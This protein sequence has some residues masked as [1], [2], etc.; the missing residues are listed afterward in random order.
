MPGGG[1]GGMLDLFEVPRGLL[2]TGVNINFYDYILLRVTVSDPDEDD[3]ELSYYDA[4][5]NSL[6]STF[7]NVPS[8]GNPGIGFSILGLSEGGLF[9]W[10]V[11]VS[12]GE[13]SINSPIY[14][15]INEY[16][17]SRKLI[18]INLFS[19][20]KKP[21]SDGSFSLYWDEPM[22]ANNYS[23]YI[24]SE[25][26]VE[27]NENVILLRSGLTEKSF[28]LQGLNDGNYYFI[29][30]GF[31]P[32]FNIYSNCIHIRVEQ[33]YLNLYLG[34]TSV[35]IGCIGA[36]LAGICIYMIKKRISS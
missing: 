11:V 28:N 35:I 6:I 27:L 21:D 24:S 12:D 15:F 19:N 3:L 1:S 8:G 10:F 31:L 26:I 4:T 17:D 2:F 9:Q 36:S 33:P 18:F 13:L 16:Y 22:N 14:Y 7:H 23:I 32:S 20:A 30:Q 34:I 29:I 5:N 25:E